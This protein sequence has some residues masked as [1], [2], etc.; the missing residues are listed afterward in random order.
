LA[1]SM[2]LDAAHGGDTRSSGSW[3]RSGRTPARFP[4]CRRRW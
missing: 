3:W 2:R 1:S 4:S